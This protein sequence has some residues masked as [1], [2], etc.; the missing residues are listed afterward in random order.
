M[1][2]RVL[3]P[4]YPCLLVGKVWAC[5]RL[6]PCRL[7]VGFSLGL[8]VSGYAMGTYLYKS[9]QLLWLCKPTSVVCCD[10]AFR[11]ADRQGFSVLQKGFWGAGRLSPPSRQEQTTK[12]LQTGASEVG[13]FVEL[14][15]TV[16]TPVLSPLLQHIP[17]LC[18]FRSQVVTAG[19]AVQTFFFY[20]GMQW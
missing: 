1:L 15:G 5:L 9:V 4:W 6:S 17:S 19:N 11:F 2:L 12:G 10:L 13:Q 20:W 14:V 7:S 18:P 8:C 3:C 16:E